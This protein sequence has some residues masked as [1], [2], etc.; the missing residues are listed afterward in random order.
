MWLIAGIMLY[1]IALFLVLQ[2]L[3]GASKADSQIRRLSRTLETPPQEPSHSQV[4]SQ[5]IGNKSKVG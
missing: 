5:Y 3:R 1:L 2:F 4:S